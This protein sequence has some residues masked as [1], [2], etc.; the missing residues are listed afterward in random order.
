MK[1]IGSR[2][3]IPEFSSTIEHAEIKG[4]NFKSDEDDVSRLPEGKLS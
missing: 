2:S 4:E 1:E 3:A